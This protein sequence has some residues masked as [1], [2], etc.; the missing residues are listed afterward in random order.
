MCEFCD[1]YFLLKT[2]KDKEL[3]LQK[4]TDIKK[5]SFEYIADCRVLI[6]AHYKG[7][8][9]PYLEGTN[10]IKK[11]EINFCPVCGRDLR[12]ENNDGK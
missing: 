12:K 7:I 1:R 4:E 5:R 3:A 2:D 9:K 10:K 6:I 11:C 8:E